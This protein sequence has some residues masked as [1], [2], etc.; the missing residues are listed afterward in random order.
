[1]PEVQFEIKGLEQLAKNR[2][3]LA[4]SFERNTIRTALRNAAKPVVAKAKAGVPVRTGALKRSIRASVKIDRAGLGTA[5][6]GFGRDQFYGGF[7]E[8]GTS[9]QAAQPFLRPALDD[10]ESESEILGAFIGS[11]NKTI[12]KGAEET[13]EHVDMA[14]LAN[15]IV[16]V[17]GNTVKL[18]KSLD[19]AQTRVGKFKGFATTALK[20]V[21]TAATG[22]AIGGAAAITG[23]GINAVKDFVQ[24]GDEL[25][26][27][28]KRLGISVESLSELKF[29]AEQSGAS[30]DDIEKGT[31]KLAST[32]FD[33][34][35]GIKAS[36][37]A[38]EALGLNAA[39][40]QDLSPEQQFL[41]VAAALAEVENASTRAALAQDVF[42]RAGTTLLPLVAE[43]A[44]GLAELRQ[45]ASDLGNTYTTEAAA[46]AALFADTLNELKQTVGGLGRE[47]GEKVVPILTRLLDWFIES[48]PQIE[49]FI[50]QVREKVGPFAEAFVS[51]AGLI[52]EA[53]GSVLS[54]IVSNKPVLLRH[55][56]RH[57][58]RHRDGAGAGVAGRAGHPGDYHRHRLGAGQLGD[59]LGQGAVHLGDHHRRHKARLRV[60]PGISASGRL[61]HQGAALL[62]EQLG[63][64]L[65]GR[66]EPLDRLSPAP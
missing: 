54:W 38:F 30:L 6:I 17:Q 59:H 4:K 61:P 10:A 29:A 65:G 48:R 64:N 35:N 14:T 12:E 27:M 33:A 47:I 28:S 9:Q 18:N 55:H 24:V 44:E 22:L 63:A 40:L 11:I 16:S 60:E 1:M 62:P 7:F 34:N 5:R 43:G 42:G 8:L 52:L 66:S 58:H 15:L 39:M 25:D 56:R 2:K 53:L 45:Q 31:K 49:A 46:K 23:F 36:S 13:G 20:A 37:D 3:L 57:W 50:A 21:R 19:A 26:K 41:A 51:G 32:V